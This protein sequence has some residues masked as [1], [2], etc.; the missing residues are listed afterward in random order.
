MSLGNCKI[1]GR[2][3]T[4][5]YPLLSGEPSFCSQHHN[6]RDAGPF[7][8]DFSGPDDFEIPT[9]YDPEEPFAL[10]MRLEEIRETKVWTTADGTELHVTEMET[11]HIENCIAF[12]YRKLWDVSEA[13]IEVFSEELERRKKRGK[14]G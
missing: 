1:C 4:V 3:A 12:H 7:G 14:D 9:E 5:V 11:G 8:C 13:W 6:E 2:E 10:E